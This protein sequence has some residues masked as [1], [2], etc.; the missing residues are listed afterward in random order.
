MAAVKVNGESEEEKREKFKMR[1]Y[2][3]MACK[4]LR[5]YGMY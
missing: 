1:S 3:F 2:D 5:F 4:E